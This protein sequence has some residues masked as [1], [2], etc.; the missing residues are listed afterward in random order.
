MGTPDLF[1]FG[2]AIVEATWD[3]ACAFKL[4][5]AFFEAHGSAGYRAME[6]IVEVHGPAGPGD[7]RREAE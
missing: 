5:L 6:R 4:N 2:R 3:L 1:D 7:R